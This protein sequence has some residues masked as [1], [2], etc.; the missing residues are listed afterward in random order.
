M[1]LASDAPTTLTR[2]RVEALIRQPEECTVAKVLEAVHAADGDEACARTLARAANG[3]EVTAELMAA[4]LPDVV[5]A[6]PFVGVIVAA[7]GDRAEE[8]VKLVERSRLTVH[9]LG[10]DN[11][12]LTLYAAARLGAGREDIL[13]RVVPHARRI[14]RKVS[15]PA[16][17]RWVVSLAEAIGD[18]QLLEAVRIWQIIAGPSGAAAAVDAHLGRSVAE[19]IAELPQETRGPRVVAGFTV[20][21]APKVGRNEL[22]P[23]GSGR[24]Y[25]RC[26]AESDAATV[27][28][29]PIASLS[30]DEYVREGASRM[31]ADDVLKLAPRD[32]MRV[33]LQGLSDDALLAAQRRF[34]AG[35]RWQSAGQVVDLLAARG[36]VDADV[37]RAA[38]ASVA[39][40]CNEVV[41]AREQLEKVRDRSVVPFGDLL[42]LALRIRAPGVLDKLVE[43]AEVA[44]RE[45]EGAATL[46]R[47]M[48][49]AT[50][51]LGI[52][53]ARG[54][55]RAEEPDEVAAVLDEIEDARDRLNLPAGDLAWDLYA[56]VQDD[57]A[58]LDELTEVESERATIEREADRLRAD[59]RAASSRLQDLESELAHRRSLEADGPRRAQT[60][61]PTRSTPGEATRAKGDEHREQ[62]RKIDELQALIRAGNEERLELR[63]RLAEASAHGRNIGASAARSQLL[64]ES[65]EDDVAAE[66]PSGN[67]QRRVRVPAFDRRATDAVGTI[68]GHVAA[69]AVRTAGELAA[70]D[71]AA[72]R[73][74]KQAKD[75]RRQMMMARIG[76][77]HR[78]L[79]RVEDDILRVVDV[80]PRENLLTTLKRLRDA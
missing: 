24:K 23:C 42:D 44:V 67:L 12:V 75:M 55:L 50:P 15:T 22:C 63:Q 77:H 35:R 52:L 41:V 54:C 49:R 9:S 73:G 14:L 47:V 21:T 48:L 58:N 64:D 31:S 2:D 70:G 51:A 3:E 74:V 26:H 32:L 79:F 29:S 30:W 11:R 20:R 8:L 72:W 53:V 59:L 16:Q 62:R 76:I 36:H 46:A 25:K 61:V 27:R 78:L 69:A 66:V 39:L 4:V 45:E 10:A 57:A 17:R 71:S 43:A 34:V 40:G 38:L 80:V 5:G 28:P 19:L 33:D 6:V 18:P 68:P 65:D 7:R 37:I 56:A 13:R 1:M 60:P